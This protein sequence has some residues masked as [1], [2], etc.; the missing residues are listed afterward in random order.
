MPRCSG[1]IAYA[2]TEETPPQ[3]GVWTE[4]ITEKKYYGDI[5]RDNR[6]VVDQSQINDNINV[7]N[8]ISVI[9]NK[10]MLENLAHMKYISFMG[11]KWKISLVDVRPPRMIITLGG[12]YNVQQNGTS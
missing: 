11:S 10:F 6:K 5:I 8:N 2:L 3:S 9:C 1:V 4:T 7:S 12:L